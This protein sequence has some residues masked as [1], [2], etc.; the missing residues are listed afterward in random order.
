[1]SNIIPILMTGSEANEY[2]SNL[3]QNL[4]ENLITRNFFACVCGLNLP[5]ISIKSRDPAF[6]KQNTQAFESNVYTMS[7]AMPKISPFY[8]PSTHFLEPNRMRRWKVQKYG[9]ANTN[10]LLFLLLFSF[11]CLQ[12]GGGGGKALQSSL[13]PAFRL[14]MS[15]IFCNCTHLGFKKGFNKTKYALFLVL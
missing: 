15:C 1:M 12:N 9:G 7:G 8:L 11:I 10:R 5:Q 3:T 4:F 13:L 14:M 2:F 6:I